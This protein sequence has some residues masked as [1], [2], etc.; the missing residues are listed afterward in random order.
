MSTV[1]RGARRADVESIWKLIRALAVY[2]KMESR[3]TGSAARLEQH[4][5]DTQKKIECLVA[6]HH[7]RLVGYAIYFPTY[8]TFRTQPMMWL[9]DLFVLPEV[10]GKG[11]GRALLAELSRTAIQRG[12]WRLDWAVLDWNEPSIKFYE[13]LGARRQNADWFV[14]GFDEERLRDLATSS[15]T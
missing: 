7:S 9:E 14:Y 1:V 11:I 2:E 10:R 3:V 5:F 6:E 4:L 13:H 15:S 12:C 8:S